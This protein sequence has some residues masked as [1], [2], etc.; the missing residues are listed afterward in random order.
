MFTP[1]KE[2]P[3]QKIYTKQPKEEHNGKWKRKF[4]TQQKSEPSYFAVISDADSRRHMRK[5]YASWS[6]G[7]DKETS[8]F[9]NTQRVYFNEDNRQC[10]DNK[11]QKD[12]VTGSKNNITEMLCKL[13]KEQLA[14]QE[15]L[16]P[17]DGNPLEYTY[18]M[19]MFKETYFEEQLRMAALVS[20]TRIPHFDPKLVSNSAVPI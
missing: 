4:K 5:L 12:L 1:T 14:P 9:S 17:F 20:N 6:N 11:I 19:S 2:Y 8:H 10:E 16:K 13:V 15:D 7:D 3:S 18:F